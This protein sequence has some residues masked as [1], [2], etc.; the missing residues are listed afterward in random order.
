MTDEALK[1]FAEMLGAK[2]EDRLLER[3][4]LEKSDDGR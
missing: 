3:I 4:K 1:L 2:K